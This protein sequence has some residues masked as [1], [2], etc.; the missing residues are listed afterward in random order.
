MHICIYAYMCVCVY[1]Y[2]Y[3]YTHVQHIYLYV[4]YVWGGWMLA[5][6]LAASLADEF[7]AGAPDEKSHLRM[8]ERLPDPVYKD[9]QQCGD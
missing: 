8:S 4:Q 6:S 5:R 3:I 9:K 1:I 7:A 2:I